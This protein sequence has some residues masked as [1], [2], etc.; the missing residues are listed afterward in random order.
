[1]GGSQAEILEMFLKRGYLSPEALKTL[2]TTGER[3][4][5]PLLEA[6]LLSG[7]LHP[8]V[9]SFLLADSLGLSFQDVDPGAVP[10]TLSELLPEAVAREHRVVPLSRDAGRLTLALA[11]PFQ[12]RVFS[13]IERTTG[14]SVR[15]VVCPPGTI[16]RVLDRLYP[17][18]QAPS[19]GELEG[20]FVSREEALEW[21]SRGKV[22]M[23]I[24][25][26]LSLAAGE[27]YSS[28]R[29]FPAGRHVR[30]SGRKEGRSTLFLSLPGRHRRDLIQALADLSGLSSIP[31]GLSETV[32]Q[33]ESPSGVVPF[34]LL[35][36]HGLSGPE[37]VVRILPDFRPTATLDSVGLTPEQVEITRKLLEKRDGLYLLSTPGPEGAATTMF[38][39]L[40]EVVSPGDRVVT[41]EER[42]RFR[43]ERYIQLE[44]RDV[45]ARYG[46]RFSRL[47]GLL[48]PDALMVESLG[49]PSDLVDL[50][51]VA[52]NGVAVLCG[53]RGSGFGDVFRSLMGLP[54]DPFLV[55]RAVR[56]ILHQRL[57]DLL[58][59]E[60]RRPV[61]A[62]PVTRPGENVRRELLGEII[63]DTS[64]YM[65]A[66]CGRCAGRGFSGKM[67][68]AEV[69][70]FTH[71][72][73][74]LLLS[75][76][77]VEE[78]IERL[79]E[80]HL[81]TAV[82]SIRELLRRGM[83]TYDDILPFFM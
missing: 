44:R 76:L 17:D 14:L 62:K 24:E 48:E 37:A 28:V 26:T 67:A 54:A 75:G 72:V 20:G 21:I 43:T 52:R 13:E 41:V 74:N 82:Q 7:I 38:A 39:M 35:L 16:D 36:F 53:V 40:R 33:M 42:F 81:Y 63:R 31:A 68:L 11:D 46:G 10:M 56:F 29:I 50:I 69:L 12:H 32:F 78:T 3:K 34:S 55:S 8:D 66:G 45:E 57:V 23:L 80:E 61:P 27:G 77:P 15:V 2:K 73:Q 83:V 70:P 30:I 47:T 6:A 1:M 79:A 71:G 9:K 49:A 51:Q 19:A 25:K 65:P 58:C 4:G 59:P 22:R 18:L 64:F 5:I 60:C